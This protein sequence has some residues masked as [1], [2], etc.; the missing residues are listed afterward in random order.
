[1][2]YRALVTLGIAVCLPFGLAFVLVPTPVAALYGVHTA[3]PGAVLMTRYFGATMLMYAAAL[4]AAR[5]LRDPA[6]QRRAAA[7]LAAA[8]ACGLVVTMH[9][10]VGGALNAL[11]WSSVGIYAFFTLA[12]A[13]LAWWPAA[14][15]THRA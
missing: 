5:D 1:M 6:A 15:A 14:L 9:G 10:V 2:N 11:G 7:A 12:W 4:W 13:R 8:V 3:D